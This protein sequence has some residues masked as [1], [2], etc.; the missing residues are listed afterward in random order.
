MEGNLGGEFMIGI[1]VSMLRSCSDVWKYTVGAGSSVYS[2]REKPFVRRW[3]EAITLPWVS[4][5]G[6]M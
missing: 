4:F 2:K 5:I 3:S 1:L 6:V